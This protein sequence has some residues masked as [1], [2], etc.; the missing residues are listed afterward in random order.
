M[1]SPKQK[2]SPHL[3]ISPGLKQI[4]TASLAC[5]LLAFV[6]AD[7]PIKKLVAKYNRFGIGSVYDFHKEKRVLQLLIQIATI[8]RLASWR[9]KGKQKLQA[10]KT[11]VGQMGTD[12]KDEL[13]DLSMHEAC[14]K[15]I[16]ANELIIE[17]RKVTKRHLSYLRDNIHAQGEHRGVGWYAQIWIPEFCEAAIMI[18][19]ANPDI[20][21]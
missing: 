18:P 17:G 8:Y 3:D 13:I 21:F 1:K 4:E 11:C 16:H 12:G 15:I 10:D 2:L 14:N 20:P 7:A 19:W 9:M 6:M 5:E